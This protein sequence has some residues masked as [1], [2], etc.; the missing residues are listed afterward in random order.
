MRVPENARANI[1]AACRWWRWLA[2]HAG[3]YAKIGGWCMPPG[4]RVSI[5]L[6]GMPKPVLPMPRADGP[7]PA[8]HECPD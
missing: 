3:G 8:S 7:F 1:L 2:S 6:A 5:M 4:K